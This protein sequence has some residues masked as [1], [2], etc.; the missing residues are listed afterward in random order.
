MSSHGIRDCQGMDV[1]WLLRTQKLTFTIAKDS[2]EAC[3][4]AEENGVDK[5]HRVETFS[6]QTVVRRNNKSKC[7]PSQR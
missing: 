4:S 1:V 6:G 3:G 5:I 2:S 7:T